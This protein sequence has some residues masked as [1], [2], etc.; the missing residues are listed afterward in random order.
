MAEL[1]EG[2]VWYKVLR[3]YLRS[4]VGKPGKVRYLPYQVPSVHY[5]VGEVRYGRWWGSRLEGSLGTYLF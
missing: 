1:R 5:A 4:K 2:C 3:T